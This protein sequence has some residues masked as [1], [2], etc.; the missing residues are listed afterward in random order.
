MKT[1]PT[2]RNQCPW[3]TFLLT[4]FITCNS[5]ADVIPDADGAVSVISVNVGST[6]TSG[7][8]SFNS[9]S[10]TTNTPLDY[11]S[12]TGLSL[13]WGI[14]DTSG[15]FMLEYYYSDAEVESPP[16]AQQGG[17]PHLKTHSLFYSGYWVPNIFWGIKGIL[18]AGIGHSIQTLT[19]TQ[20]P[21]LE[22]HGWSLKTSAGLEYAVMGRLSVYALAEGI[23][24]H[25]MEDRVNHTSDNA[26][27]TKAVKRSI[28]GN[29]QVRLSLGVNFRF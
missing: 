29:E 4:T 28:S 8:Y 1:L 20:L 3:A 24:I 22:D 15:R 9:N 21:E 19:H 17:L 10:D 14:E 12:S 26:S 18:G 7:K 2:R 13:A 5:A 11:A 27:T 23:L 16:F 6:D 25:D